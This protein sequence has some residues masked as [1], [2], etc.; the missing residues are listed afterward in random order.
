MI[1]GGLVLL[2]EIRMPDMRAEH[3]SDSDIAGYLD[4]DLAASDRSRVEAHMEACVACRTAMVE[5]MRAADGAVQRAGTST[6]VVR[7]GSSRWITTGVG[8]AAA[9]GIAALM[10]VRPE[11]PQG[12]PPERATPTSIE[13]RRTIEIV[14][15]PDRATVA[16]AALRF[17]WRGTRS[18]L[19]KVSLLSESGEL[20]W[21]GETA[22]TTLA[23]ADGIRL[24]RGK[25][26]FWRVDGVTAGITA[27][28]AAPSFTIR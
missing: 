22:D 5:V 13:A 17:T 3:L 23:L 28:T 20:L 1:P 15:P 25:T 24:E 16:R 2:V 14:S 4:D 6:S 18:D 7:G 26:Y 21:S 8:L 12:S 19:Y 11:T 9:A 27:S 10:L